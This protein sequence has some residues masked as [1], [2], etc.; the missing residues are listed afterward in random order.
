M[1]TLPPD[2]CLVPEYLCQS[3]IA[4]SF[5]IHLIIHSLKQYPFKYN[6]SIRQSNIQHKSPEAKGRMFSPQQHNAN[7]D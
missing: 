7:P 4:S 6:I 2:L 1:Y 3:R 5:L